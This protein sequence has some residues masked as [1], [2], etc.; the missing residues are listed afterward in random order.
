MQNSLL[1]G[2]SRQMSLSHQI[3]IIANNI[4]NIDTTGFKADNAAFSQ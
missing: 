3:D 1:V 2:L 4:A